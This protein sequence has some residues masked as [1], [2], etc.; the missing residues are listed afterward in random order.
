MLISFFQGTKKTSLVGGYYWLK[1]KTLGYPN[2]PPSFRKVKL[3]QKYKLLLKFI[4][5]KFT[6]KILSCQYLAFAVMIIS[7]GTHINLRLQRKRKDW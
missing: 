4:R 5:G 2:K 7:D 1:P 3:N 6:S